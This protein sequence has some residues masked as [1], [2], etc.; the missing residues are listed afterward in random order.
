MAA[1]LLLFSY[2]GAARTLMPKPGPWMETLK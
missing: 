1:P 2:S